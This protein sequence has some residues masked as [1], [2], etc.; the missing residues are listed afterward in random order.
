MTAMQK[1]NTPTIV[2]VIAFA[3][4]FRFFTAG[5]GAAFGDAVPGA[6]EFCMGPV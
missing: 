6:T 3:R 5:R 2:H 4:R 1:T